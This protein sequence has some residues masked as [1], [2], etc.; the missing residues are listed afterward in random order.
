MVLFTGVMYLYSEQRG[1]T[2]GE[3]IVV[4]ASGAMSIGLIATLINATRF[5]WGMRIVA[6]VIFVA[7]LSYLF[8]EFWYTEKPLA[9]DNSHGEG[10]PF[11]AILGFLFFGVPCLLYTFWGSTWG[12]LGQAEPQNIDRWDVATA[13]LAWGAHWLFLAL[14]ALAVAAGLWRSYL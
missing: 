6:F 2:T 1:W 14:S 11:E 10:S 3:S 8:H 4:G 5:W 7:Y 13:Y 12:K 9:V